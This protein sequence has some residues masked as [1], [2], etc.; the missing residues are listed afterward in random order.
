MNKEVTFL[1]EIDRKRVV[2]PEPFTIEEFV[3]VKGDPTSN[4][5]IEKY[6]SYRIQFQNEIK[7][8]KLSANRNVDEFSE[9]VYLGK[10]YSDDSFACKSET[11]WEIIYGQ[12]NSGLY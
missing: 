6:V 5:N 2:R 1:K 11:H 12:L 10:S 7:K 4:E 3:G 9:I 8:I